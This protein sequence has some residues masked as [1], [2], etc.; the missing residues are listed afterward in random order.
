MDHID[1]HSDN[2]HPPLAVPYLH[3]NRAFGYDHK[4]FVDFPKR[5]GVVPENI[6]QGQLNGLSQLDGITFLQSWCFFGL[7]F[8]FLSIVGR[9]RTIEDFVQREPSAVGAALA[10]SVISTKHLPLLVRE[11]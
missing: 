11:L 5:I 2:Y 9:S 6:L 1:L 4:G 8:E 10:S 7:L 3:G